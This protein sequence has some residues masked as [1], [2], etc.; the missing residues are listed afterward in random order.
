MTLLYYQAN[1]TQAIRYHDKALSIDPNGT[2][3][4]T[5]KGKVFVDQGNYTQALQ[6][7][8][9]ALALNSTDAGALFEKQNAIS[10]IVAYVST[11][12]YNRGCIDVQIPNPSERYINQFKNGSNAFIQ[13]Y[14]EGFDVCSGNLPKLG[15]SLKTFNI[16]VLKDNIT[17]ETANT[18]I[19]T[20]VSEG[21]PQAI[22]QNSD[23][24]KPENGS[25]S[26]ESNILTFDSV[27]VNASF[28]S[29]IQC[30]IYPNV[31]L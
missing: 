24:L 2:Y 9:K 11:S 13:I 6:Y 22:C 21:Y 20:T 15:E 18:R 3:A 25:N 1:Y 10:K 17:D 5:G 8:K 31:T 7:Y 27:P 14:N 26:I 28:H 30:L 19:C 4:L 12:G 16:I 23:N 29:C